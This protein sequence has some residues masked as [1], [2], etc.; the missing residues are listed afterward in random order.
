MDWSTNYASGPEIKAYWKSMVKKHD[1]QKYITYN[2]T[3]TRAEWSESKGKWV[4]NVIIDGKDSVDEADF[5]ITATGHFSTPLL[6]NYPGIEKYTGH[7]RHSS[8]WDPNFDPTG[9]SVAL[10]GNGASGLQILPPLQQMVKQLDHY[11][12]SPTWIAGSFGGE[13][14]FSY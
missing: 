9:K 11:A 3:I 8:N 2:S 5:L 6:P 13:G 4:I 10:I 12:R 1:V 7:L 14:W